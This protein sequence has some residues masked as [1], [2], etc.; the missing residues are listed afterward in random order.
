MSGDGFKWEGD[1]FTSIDGLDDRVRRAVYA[2]ARYTAEH[3]ESFMKS[4]APWTDRTGNAR[5]GL[6]AQ[7]VQNGDEV[8]IVMFHSVSYGP[9]LELRWGGKYG[10]IPQA[11]AA[12]GPM[13][14]ETLGR[15]VA[16]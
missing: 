12:A 9:W 6:R 8:G 3:A 2:S 10:I 4:E 14:V 16:G 7:V 1:L 15:L 11:M 13:W 5:R